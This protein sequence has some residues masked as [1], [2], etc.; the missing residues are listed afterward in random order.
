MKKAL[1]T[2]LVILLATLLCT[3]CSKDEESVAEKAPGKIDQINKK[4][5][6]AIVKRIKTPLD[7]ARLTQGLGDKRMEE[8]D[9]TFQEQ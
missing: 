4:T 1:G 2:I 5:A 8:M 6:D 3:A 9:K 7:K